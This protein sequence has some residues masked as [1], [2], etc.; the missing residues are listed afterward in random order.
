M[1]FQMFYSRAIRRLAGTMTMCAVLATT[2][3]AQTPSQV[4]LLNR[5][6]GGVPPNVMLTVDDSGSMMF[7]HMPEDKIKV[8]GWAAIASPV[9][10][11]SIRFDPGDSYGILSGF[12]IGT[13]AGNL[14]TNRWQQMAMRSPDTNTIFYNPELRYLPWAVATYPLPAATATNPA[15]RMA[16]SPPNAA[17]EDP[18]NPGSGTIN[19]NATASTFTS[20]TWCFSNSNNASNC[21]SAGT[22]TSKK[23]SHDPGV[24]FRLK[25][26]AAGVY[27]DPK[28]ATSYTGLTINAT[29]GS[30]YTK[31]QKRT[32]CAGTFC[33]QTEERQNFANW[34]SYYRTRNLLARGSLTEAF[35]TS[36]NTF[37]VGF[38][39]INKGSGTV[40]GASTA[41][42]ESNTSTYGGGGVR[43][44]DVGRKAQFFK[45]IQD[46]PAS[47][48]TSLPGALDAVGKY[49]SRT[50]AKGPW[51]DDPGDSDNKVANNK[52]C[53]R[54]YN[55]MMTDGYWNSNPNSL[56][57]DK[58]SDNTDGPLIKHADGIK[59]YQ[60]KAGT[61][62][63]AD[64]TAYTLADYA[65]HYW[66]TDLQPATANAVV[67]IGDNVSFWQNLTN[68]TIG[69]GVTGSLDPTTDLGALTD[70]S[71]SWPAA[72]TAGN[73]YNVDDL[74]HAAVNSRG[75]YFSA[76]DPAELAGAISTALGSAIG[77]S[78]ATAGVATASTVLEASNRKYVPTYISGTWSGDVSAK[79]LDVNGQETSAVWFASAKWPVKP[80]TVGGTDWNQRKIFTWDPD[81]VG[82][83]QAVPL[84]WAAISAPSRSALGS[85][86]ATYTSQFVDFLRGDHSNEGTSI[87]TPFRLREDSQGVPFVLGDFVNSTPVFLQGNVDSNYSGLA[88]GGSSY[89]TFLNFKASRLGVLVV[90][91][92]DGMLHA[93]QDSK[94]TPAT[95][96]Q[97][98][99][100]YVPRAVYPNLSKLADK[101]YGTVALPH[102]YFVDGPQNEAD[103]YV[104]A[105]GATPGT[106][107]ASASWRNYL[108]GSLGAG[109]QAVY[110]LDV[111]DTSNLG[112][113][114]VRWEISNA[115][116]ADVG[117]VMS[118][119]EVGVLP[120]GKWVALFGNGNSSS[121]G[122]AVLFVVDL[123]TGA[124][125][126]LTVDASSGNGLG[127]V[128]VQKDATGQ[129]VRIYAG[130]LKGNLWRMDY[131]STTASNFKTY[132]ESGVDKPLFIARTSGG[133]V[134]PISQPPILYDHSLGGTLVVFG[135]GQ[136]F[137]A[138][139]ASNTTLQ[140]M[141]GI[142]DKVTGSVP[143]PAFPRAITRA[144]LAARTVTQ[145]TGDKGAVF[146]SLSG[147]PVDWTTQRGWV[148]DL[149]S[150]SGLR[151]IY[152]P[153]K[154]SFEL[155][156]ISTVAPAQAAAVCQSTDGKGINFLIDV[157]QGANPPF[158]AMDTNGDG[159]VN[160]LDTVAGGYATTADGIDRVIYSP[161][162]ASST[163]GEGGA[164]DG[165]CGAGFFQT[166]I[167][168]ASGQVLTC[169]RNKGTPPT[170]NIKD[171]V[172]RRI[173]NPP[174]R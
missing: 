101:T 66:K 91:G 123:E 157:E 109:G 129:I 27:L 114:T 156:L 102:Q 141:Y 39:R 74:W 38:G 49:F 19:L 174:V 42:L 44:F 95:D 105:P 136:L 50:D 63:Y 127:G 96:G 125:N 162:K 126:K 73:Q 143:D 107:A 137:S 59:T 111:T 153:Q 124:F 154:I 61:K 169:L 21:G 36:T 99:F 47:G 71:K 87:A 164:G 37:R 7:Q 155:A 149:D 135:T 122:K 158:N 89:Q 33:T 139:D 128:A 98:V 81:A 151:T 23:V 57:S 168:N 31:Y 160:A 24:Y 46:L 2:V 142:W 161:K 108:T 163:P 132:Q 166:S 16:N 82:G 65:M 43:D 40:D 130:D 15:G 34:F 93:F 97:E 112:A 62:P 131:N 172:Q 3:L 5:N 78:A 79:P 10:T 171:R 75:A 14:S 134:Q 51:T 76:K 150:I 41:V 56:G 45:W 11:Q 64:G 35:S 84:T 121:L 67:P 29:S 4:P 52:T 58:N 113:S 12:F 20:G 170:P 100:A 32:D 120:N 69:L 103:A 165:I 140:S 133:L 80:T 138:A 116:D 54:S 72:T 18:M 70:G 83:A 53:R 17:F 90:G 22:T 152:P 28:L 77:G 6:G 110:A 8:A 117:Y 92:N 26:D 106:F 9:G 48:G 85:V 144:S 60:F 145:F 30:T 13:I 1:I 55:I 25:K 148:T 173:I 146:Y 88:T 159:A 104:R 118:P 147:T 94:V 68:F 86:A 115:N 119:I 167:Q